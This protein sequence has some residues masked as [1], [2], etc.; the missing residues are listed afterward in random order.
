MAVQTLAQMHQ[1]TSAPQLPGTWK[2]GAGR[3][4]T[5]RP[6]ESGFVRVAHGQLWA[7]FEGPH[8]GPLNDQGDHVLGVGGRLWVR[9]GQKIVIQ[10]WDR[11]IPAFFSWDPAPAAA[12]A[13]AVTLASVLQPLADLRL[14]VAFGAGA[15][16][17][18]VAGFVRLAWDVVAV[19]ERVALPDCLTADA[20]ACRAHGAMS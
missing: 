1:S 7:T 11:D 16:A 6:S 15:A 18:L 9:A 4:I 3:A 2:L 17:R 13:P 10:A 8:Q 14:A 5:L 20:R 12:V 19:R